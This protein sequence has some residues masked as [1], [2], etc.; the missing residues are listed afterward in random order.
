MSNVKFVILQK[1]ALEWV[2]SV[3]QTNLTVKL[4]IDVDERVLLMNGGNARIRPVI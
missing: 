3:K 2:L 1:L 4:A